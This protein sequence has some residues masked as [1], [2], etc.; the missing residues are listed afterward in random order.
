MGF[1]GFAVLADVAHV[2]DVGVDPA[3][4][5]RGIGSRLCRAVMDE[6]WRRGVSGVTLEVRRSNAAARALYRGL[7]MTESGLRPRY[8]P[9]GECAV[10]FWARPSTVE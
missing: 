9:D 8:Y 10:I 2:L 6:A 5:R 3:H 4:Q 1:A 7:G